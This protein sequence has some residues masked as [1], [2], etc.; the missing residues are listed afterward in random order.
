MFGQQL[1]D[2]FQEA[3]G[4]EMPIGLVDSSWA[5]TIIEAWSPPE[6]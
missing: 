2:D 4:V 3:L 5:G 6:V 1:S